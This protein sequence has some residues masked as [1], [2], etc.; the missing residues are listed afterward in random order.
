[1]CKTPT[2]Q[3][4]V[5]SSYVESARYDANFRVNDEVLSR[6][7]KGIK[8]LSGHRYGTSAGTVTACIRLRLTNGSEKRYFLK[9]APGGHGRTMIESEFNAMSELSKWA[10]FLAPEPHSWGRYKLDEPEAYFFLSQ[11]IEMNDE[12]PEPTQLCEKLA[13]LHRESISPNGQYG[14]HIT[15]CQGQVA[16]SVSWEQDWTLFFIKLLEHVINLD[17]ERN[18]DWS[19]LDRV[20]RR[21]IDSVIPRFWEL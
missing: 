14:F 20:E 1:M 16:Q 2:L 11:Y 12:M 8:V 7:P 15:T 10:P 5:D 17:F 9:S 3:A 19:E 18:G 6:F 4:L 13:R 21:L